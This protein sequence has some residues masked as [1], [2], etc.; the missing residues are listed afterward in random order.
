MVARFI[1]VHP[2]KR[3]GKRAEF[4]VKDDLTGNY[5]FGPVFKRSEAED[6]QK[7]LNDQAPQQQAAA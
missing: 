4:Y 7:K 6:E 2:A 1:L 5:V 3:N